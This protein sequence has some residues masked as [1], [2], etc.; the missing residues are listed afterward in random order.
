MRGASLE[1]AADAACYIRDA[2][3]SVLHDL[4]A[5]RLAVFAPSGVPGRKSAAAPFPG[6]GHAGIGQPPHDGGYPNGNAAKLP[7][8]L[9]ATLMAAAAIVLFAA[10][11][12]RPSFRPGGVPDGR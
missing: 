7:S 6:S 8:W 10:G 2:L 1:Q 11:G 5:G 12:V 4:R 3:A 9:T